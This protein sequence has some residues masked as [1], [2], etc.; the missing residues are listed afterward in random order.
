MAEGKQE[1]KVEEIHTIG[2]E[3][4]DATDDAGRWTN[5]YFMSSADIVKQS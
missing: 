4:M 3:I 5:F 2:S 1:V